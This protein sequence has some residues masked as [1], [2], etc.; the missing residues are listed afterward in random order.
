MFEYPYIIDII[1]SV[2]PPYQPFKKYVK[3]KDLIEVLDK[4]WEED[5]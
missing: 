2:K 5:D 3:L 4:A 1:H